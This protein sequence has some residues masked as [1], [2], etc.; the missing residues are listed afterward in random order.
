MS[1]KHYRG[2]SI[3]RGAA[4][5]LIMLYHYTVRYNENPNTSGYRIDWLLTFDWGCAAV[6]TLF[7]LSGFLGA[8]HF[9]VQG[10]VNKS[11]LFLKN[12]VVRLY[13]SFIVCLFIS[14]LV[15]F[16]SFPERG[17]T[18]VDLLLN[19]TMVPD[20]LGAKY[21]DGVYWT[22]QVEWVFYLVVGVLISINH[23]PT[24]TRILGFWL[25]ISYC[26]ILV[27]FLFPNMPYIDGVSTLVAA[28]H[29]QEFI[30]GSSLFFLLKNSRDYQY[31]F[32]LILCIPLQYINLDIIH[33]IALF[34]SLLLILVV[35]KCETDKFFKDP[36]SKLLIWYGKISYPFYLVHQIVGFAILRKCVSM[37]YNNTS[38]I[39]IP[40][41]ILTFLAYLIYRY[42][43]MPVIQ[44]YKSRV[45]V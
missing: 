25:L 45:H 32:L 18:I 22:L 40:F 4:A 44:F 43:E 26:I 28:T 12:R 42:V 27:G 13:P 38:I 33:F 3:I 17:C 7:V 1:D 21:I 39:L 11:T 15:S 23:Q 8:K 31:W 16:I 41:L 35:V 29:S 34:V 5:I 19:L 6:S 2:L 30:A 24:R 37:G 9:S 14:S 20:F 36:V 10:S